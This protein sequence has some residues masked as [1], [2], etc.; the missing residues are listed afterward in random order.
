M[1]LN[2]IVNAPDQFVSRSPHLVVNQ[3]DWIQTRYLFVK[4]AEDDG[5]LPTPTDY[6]RIKP[7][8]PEYPQD[9]ALAAKGVNNVYISIPLGVFSSEKRPLVKGLSLPKRKKLVTSLPHRNKRQKLL[10]PDRKS[11]ELTEQDDDV[12]VLEDD[13]IT[14]QEDDDTKSVQTTQSDVDALQLLEDR[15]TDDLDENALRDRRAGIFTGKREE[16]ANP[17]EEGTPKKRA[18]QQPM[19][20]DPPTTDFVPGSLNH[21]TLRILKP[22]NYATPG[23]T[24]TLQRE[25]QAVLG[26]QAAQPIH[27]LGWYING[28]EISNVYQ[29]IVELHT[30]DPALPLAQDLKR[31]GRTSIVL[32]VRFGQDF[33]LTPPFVRVIRPR[34]VTFAQG[35]GGHVTAGGALCMEVSFI[36][37]L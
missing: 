8:C 5:L 18:E 21:G 28:A 33:P 29:W 6:A 31:M 4:T 12:V 19:A 10:T 23:A 2:E 17:S 30:F 13:E 34:F 35:G 7:P 16:A 32:E 37:F 20:L 3:L 25:I 9:P 1:C 36:L 11:R 27:E 22:P 14:P 24:R 26:A 15:M